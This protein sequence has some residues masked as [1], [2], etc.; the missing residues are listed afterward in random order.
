M[1]LEGAKREYPEGP[2]GDGKGHE[3]IGKG[4][5]VD[6]V[7]PR[8][9]VSRLRRMEDQGPEGHMNTMRA[10]GAMRGLRLNQKH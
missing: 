5:R 3:G 6:T 9:E 10:V 2:P 4:Q 8:N 1:A 7:R